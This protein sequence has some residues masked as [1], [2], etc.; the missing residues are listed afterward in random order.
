MYNRPFV[1][2]AIHL[3]CLHQ[4]P[5]PGLS[6]FGFLMQQKMRHHWQIAK[7]A[8]FIP[9]TLSSS[10]LGTPKQQMHKIDTLP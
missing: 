10:L 8:Y 3:N 9:K 6:G 5:A 2:S 7:A 4:M 1:G